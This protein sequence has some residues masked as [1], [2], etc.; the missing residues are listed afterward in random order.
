MA[1]KTLQMKIGELAEQ[2]G[3]HVETIRYY[4]SLGLL[5]KPARTQGSVRRYGAEAVDRVRFIKRAQGLGFSLG[6]MT[7]LLDLAVGEHCKE[8][9]MFAEQKKRL[10]EEKIAELR[11]IRAALDKLIRRCITGRRGRGCPIIESLSGRAWP[12]VES[13]IRCRLR[14]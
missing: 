10:V 1:Q 12:V 3:V 14:V 2:A 4:Q 5:P 13:A 11:S 6:E 8:T 9:R 7:L